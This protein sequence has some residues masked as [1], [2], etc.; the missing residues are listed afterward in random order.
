[1]AVFTDS[2]IGGRFEVIRKG[3]ISS[4]EDWHLVDAYP[5]YIAKYGSY[6]VENKKET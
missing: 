1:M 6:S 3:K 5:Y 2:Y 4:L